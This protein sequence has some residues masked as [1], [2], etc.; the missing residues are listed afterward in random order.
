MN[1]KPDKPPRRFVLPSGQRV[2]VV[3]LERDAHAPRPLHTC[4]Q[5]SSPL[6]QPLRWREL[7]DPGWELILH[8]PNCD[9]LAAGLVT[10]A[11]IERLEDELDAGLAEMLADLR[12]LTQANMADEIDRFMSAVELGLILPEDF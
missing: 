8:C 2:E 7:G 10:E 9:W 5:C 1:H 6:V 12:R 11:E 3:N 4:L